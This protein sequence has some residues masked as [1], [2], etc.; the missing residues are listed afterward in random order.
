MFMGDMMNTLY[1]YLLQL[2]QT[3]ENPLLYSIAAWTIQQFADW[4]LDSMEPAQIDLLMNTLLQKMFNEDRKIQNSSV[5]CI[6]ILVET[7]EEKCQGY[8][9]AI[10]RTICQCFTFYCVDLSRGNDP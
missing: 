8:Y 1:P 2:I 6:A 5:T 4:L 3:N 7:G 10:I 9:D